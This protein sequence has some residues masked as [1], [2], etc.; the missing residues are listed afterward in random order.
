VVFDVQLLQLGGQGGQPV[1]LSWKFP[2]AHWTHNFVLLAT[3][4]PGGAPGRQAPPVV[5]K[6]PM[7]HV[8]LAVAV[9]VATPVAQAVQVPVLDRK[10]P[11]AHTV[12]A[13]DVQVTQPV[14]QAAQSGGEAEVA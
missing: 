10:Y 1:L 6:E 5:I 14:P 12:Q 4:Q 13:V 3:K 7:I 11:A 8:V 2:G 9:Q